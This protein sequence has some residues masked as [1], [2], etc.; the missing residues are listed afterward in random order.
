M[1][2]ITCL[3]EISQALN[4]LDL[5]TFLQKVLRNTFNELQK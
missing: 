1:D 3:Y 2:Q 4:A 5:K